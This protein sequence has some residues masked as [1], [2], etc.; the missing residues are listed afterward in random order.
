MYK[1]ILKISENGKYVIWG[2]S[3]IITTY[4]VGVMDDRLE[5]I[6]HR[7]YWWQIKNIEIWDINQQ[8]IV[9]ILHKKE[10]FD[11]KFLKNPDN[12]PCDY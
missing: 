9:N 11:M 6:L 7:L 12:L 8:Y 1:I 5:K 10:I 4:F 2:S 3:L